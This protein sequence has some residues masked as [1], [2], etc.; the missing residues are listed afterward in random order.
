MTDGTTWLAAR[1]SIAF[2]GHYVVLA[3]GVS[4]DEL[5]DRLAATVLYDTEHTAVTVGD[6]T[7][8]SLSE[9]I[10]DTY[11]DYYD[12]IGLRLGRNGDWTYA[13]AYGGRPGE[14][15]SP[16]PVSR[17]G[18][19]VCLLEYDEDNGKPVPPHFAYFHA[20]RPVSAFNMHLDASW[21]YQGSSATPPRP[22]GCRT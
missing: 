12:G 17:G 10:N 5:A 21:G 16:E 8:E 4:P 6:H 22:P 11:G 1:Q 18:V 2:G 20:A 19:H 3:R 15:D 14:F 13:V 9:L 7:G